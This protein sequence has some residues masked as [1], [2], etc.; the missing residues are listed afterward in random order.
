MLNNVNCV[1]GLCDHCFLYDVGRF[2]V[3][4]YAYMCVRV[5]VCKPAEGFFLIVFIEFFDQIFVCSD[6]LLLF[7]S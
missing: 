4:K 7:F 3:L 2:G 1:C 5:C 6:F